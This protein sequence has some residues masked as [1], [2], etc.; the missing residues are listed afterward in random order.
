MR[1]PPPSLEGGET[2]LHG[3]SCSL[4]A[5]LLAG[6]LAGLRAAALLLAGLRAA[7][8]LPAVAGA[9]WSSPLD[10]VAAADAAAEGLLCCGMCGLFCC[11]WRGCVWASAN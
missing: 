3:G 2:Y 7:A 8:S 5:G 9:A 11:V 4:F 10:A 1:L 6:L